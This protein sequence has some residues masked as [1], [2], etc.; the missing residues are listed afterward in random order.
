MGYYVRLRRNG[1]KVGELGPFT[2]RALAIRQAQPLADDA[3][4]DVVV[5]VENATSRRRNAGAKKPKR[6]HATMKKLGKRFKAT[7]MES[8]IPRPMRRPLLAFAYALMDP[9][10]PL[11]DKYLAVGGAAP[12]A[13]V[14]GPFPIGDFAAAGLTLYKMNRLPQDK[15]REQA[16]KALARAANPRPRRRAA[17][18]P[19]RRNGLVRVP[20]AWTDALTEQYKTGKGKTFGMPLSAFPYS[21]A[22][23]NEGLAKVWPG[24]VVPIRLTIKS[25]LGSAA[26]VASRE[27][28]GGVPGVR[29]AIKKGL[30]AGR[31]RSTI[32]HEL[33]HAIQFIGDDALK[34]IG[35]GMGKKKKDPFGRPPP[36]VTR[37]LRGFRKAAKYGHLKGQVSGSTIYA[38]SPSEFYPLIGSAADY[39]AG[40]YLPPNPT[41][42]QINAAIRKFL[43]KSSKAGWVREM[44]KGPGRR[45]ALAQLY[46]EV[47]RR[48]RGED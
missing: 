7:V 8:S 9:K 25:S 36:A 19:R 31:S 40:Q 37:Q 44:M 34:S 2:T 20:K 46:T 26:G 16:D 22:K 24:G 42:A 4:S 15:H 5:T 43:K 13:A 3:A 47:V 33:R 30:G 28:N 35:L 27:M 11:A 21:N 10:V 45:V 38:Q 48:S 1:R 29:I 12:M 23:L 17:S 39:I 6:S 32:R 41:D 14:D 18:T